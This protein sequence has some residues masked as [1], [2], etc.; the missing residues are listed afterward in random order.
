MSFS[1]W[2]HLIMFEIIIQCYSLP[3][4]SLVF[5]LI[6]FFL[7][8][9]HLFN[10][11]ITFA[12][13]PKWLTSISEKFQNYQTLPR[14]WLHYLRKFSADVIDDNEVTT[15]LDLVFCLVKSFKILCNPWMWKCLP[16]ELFNFRIIL[17]TRNHRLT[18]NGW[19]LKFFVE[20]VYVHMLQDMKWSQILQNINK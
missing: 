16:I 9:M 11:L 8:L 3:L 19:A 1:L 5:F 10:P 18:F 14:S 15:T 2:V 13:I 12:N 17:N 7:H 6:H 20:N 4:L